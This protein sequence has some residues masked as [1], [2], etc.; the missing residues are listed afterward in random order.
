M[1]LATSL[2]HRVAQIHRDL[3]E[4]S[5]DLILS[6]M[7]QSSEEDLDNEILFYD[8]TLVVAGLNNP[9][10]RRRKIKLSELIDQPWNLPPPNTVI[11]MLIEEAFRAKGLHVPRRNVMTRA[12]HDPGL[13]DQ[14]CQVDFATTRPGVMPSRNND[15]GIIE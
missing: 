10:P 15:H 8:R 9:W 6:R 4:R 3:R 12:L 2:W 13:V 14:V 5:V 11:G 7:A 1:R